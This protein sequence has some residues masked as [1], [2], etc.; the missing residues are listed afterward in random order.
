MPLFF[1]GLFSQVVFKPVLRPLVRVFSGLVAIPVFRFLLRRVLRVH[2]NDAELERDLE[3]WF[4]GAILL[5]AATKNLEDFLF[6]WTEWSKDWLTLALRLLL[7]VGVIESMPDQDLF[8]LVHKGPPRLRWSPAGL[9]EAWAR[10]MDFLRGVC[11]IHL[12][13]SSP[14][15]IIMCVVIGAER[16]DAERTVGWCCYGLAV[17]QYLIIAL[18]TDRDRAASLL[19]ELN[20]ELIPRREAQLR[21]AAGDS[22]AFCDD[23]D[24][25]P[26]HRR[27]GRGA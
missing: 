4:R 12:K 13:R 18:T 24:Q 15:L 7:A 16:G 21:A 23:D 25:Q 2:T 22:A 19:A 27:P 26:G 3:H 20:A 8:G 11:V 9:R 10:R 1:A 14:V 5:L 17:A 6:G